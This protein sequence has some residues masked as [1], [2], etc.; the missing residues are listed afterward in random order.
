[1]CGW[2]SDEQHPH[3]LGACWKWEIP[4]RPPD[5]LNLS[6]HLNKIPRTSVCTL[7]FKQLT[8]FSFV[9]A[10][11]YP[12][13]GQLYPR[14]HWCAWWV[15]WS[16]SPPGRGPRLFLP[17]EGPCKRRQRT[18]PSSWSRKRQVGLLRLGKVKANPVIPNWMEC[19]ATGT[20][21]TFRIGLHRI[22]TE[23]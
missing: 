8:R 10:G 2:S 1:M 9:F 15:Q 14:L 3:H 6:L 23:F 20:Q 16:A 22:V 11:F 13:N 17:P 21:E 4:A 19:P 7:M 12:E 5:P 18:R